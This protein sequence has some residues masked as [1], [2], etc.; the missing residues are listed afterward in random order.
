MTRATARV[1]S[2]GQLT[3]PKAVREHLGIRRGDELEFVAGRGGVMI[4]KRVRGSRFGQ[5]VGFL[6]GKRG[7]D[8]DSLV[9]E[10][11]GE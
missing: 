8:P 9:R 11:R 4:R 10:M 1:T 7:Q 2:K 5:W 3:I 6:K